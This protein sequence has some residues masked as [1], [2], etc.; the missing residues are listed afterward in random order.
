[1]L[2]L[3]LLGFGNDYDLFLD[4][5]NFFELQGKFLVEVIDF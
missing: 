2:W 3:N 5:G 1:M 4:K